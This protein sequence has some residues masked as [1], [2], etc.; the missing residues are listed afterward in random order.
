MTSSA[1][2]SSVAGISRPSALCWPLN[3]QVGW[4]FPT[5]DTVNI[6]SCMTVKIDEIDT[7]RRKTAIGGVIAKRKNAW[8]PVAVGQ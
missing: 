4:P 1:R 2:A 8:Q 7:I 3:R 5:Q 6:T